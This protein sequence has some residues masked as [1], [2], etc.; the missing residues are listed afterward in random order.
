VPPIFQYAGQM[1]GLNLFPAQHG[2]SHF[3]EIL[4]MFKPHVIPLESVYTDSDKAASSNVLKLWTDFAKTGNPTPDP[5]A[6][7]WTRSTLAMKHF[8]K[9]F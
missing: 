8:L 4:L 2:V 3:D 9:C 7:Q 5:K 6:T 1:L